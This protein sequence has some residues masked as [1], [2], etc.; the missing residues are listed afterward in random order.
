MVEE[1]PDLRGR[2]DVT[3][4]GR[5]GVPVCRR[6]HLITALLVIVGVLG[7][8]TATFLAMDLS[9]EGL[10]G[11]LGEGKAD[12]T[13]QVREG[14]G[15]LVQGATVTYVDGSKSSVTGITGYYFLEDVDTGKVKIRMEAEGYVTVIKTVYLE[16]GNYILDFYAEK[17]EGTVEVKGDPVAQPADALPG[18]ILLVIGIAACSV[19]AFI[20]AIAAYLH[21]WYPLVIIG[22]LLGILTWGWFIGSIISV[23]CLLIALPLRGEF[24]RNANVC[25]VP[26][27]EPPPPSIETPNDE[28]LEV[29]PVAG[30]DA[31][32]DEPGGMSPGR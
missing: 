7:L 18:R 15:R 20:A 1:S 14:D 26:W 4:M 9:G 3:F 22:S 16:R 23:A 13:G 10:D 2:L 30:H 25:E 28:V 11:I 19:M 24:G 5:S 17:G 31:R 12:I 32:S 8:A 29:T 21:R 6:L 27:S